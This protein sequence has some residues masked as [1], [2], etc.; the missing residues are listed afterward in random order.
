[1]SLAVG[2]ERRPNSASRGVASFMSRA[3]V[4]WRMGAK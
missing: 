3:L 2:A 4:A 1:M